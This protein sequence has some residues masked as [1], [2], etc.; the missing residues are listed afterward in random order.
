V[1]LRWAYIVKC[2]SVVKDAT[3]EVAELRCT[4]DAA[5]GRDSVTSDGRKVKGTVHWVSARHAHDAEVRLYD[6]LFSSP[7]PE[8]G[9]EGQ[10]F[11]TNLNPA[12]LEVIAA[13]KV[14]PS[15]AGAPVGARCQF[16]RVGYFSK[17]PDSTPDRPVFNRTVG[18]RDT[19]ARI[20]QRSG[21]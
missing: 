19:W 11:T 2:T 21:G 5:T 4:Y 6:R 7:D 17:D 15:V 18:L 1:R 8:N 13:A 9:P 12:S 20:E 10:D 3:G 14:E 16:E